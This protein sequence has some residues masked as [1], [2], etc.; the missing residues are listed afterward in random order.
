MGQKVHPIGFRLGGIQD[1]QSKWFATKN[2]AHDLHEDLQIRDIIFKRLPHTGIPKV[3][4]ERFGQKM[5]V[6][7]HT[8]R[9]GVVIG[10]SGAEV[11]RLREVIQRFT[12]QEIQIDIYEIRQ[13]EIDAQLVAENIALQ[14]EK[15]IS[16]RRAMKQAVATAM[17][18][19]AQG[20]KVSCAGR[21][22]GA[23]IARTEWYREGRVPLH[24][25][26]GDIDY[27][28][29]EAK[30]T[31]GQIGVKVWTFKGEILPK[32]EERKLH[33]KDSVEKISGGET[34]QPKKRAEKK[35]YKDKEE[36][37]ESEL[38]KEKVSE[39]LKGE[40]EEPQREEQDQ[41]IEEPID[42]ST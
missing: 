23:E 37:G 13:P 7:I 19:G 22:A 35:I 39:G 25:I 16:F 15:R 4:I 2:Y 9:P 3:I 30:T 32:L 41:K 1:W 34:L 11:E 27:G 40:G 6:N 28:F 42:V 17:R 5:K 20:V 18:F 21:L 31:Y 24:T 29:A 10:K 8:A 36:I 14:I 38:S 26:R 33:Q 12:S